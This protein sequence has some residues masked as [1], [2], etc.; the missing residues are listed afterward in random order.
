MDDTTLPNGMTTRQ[1]DAWLAEKL[2]H[3]QW[4]KNGDCRFLAPSEGPDADEWVEY[5]PLADGTER[6]GVSEIPLLSTTWEGMGMVEE[7]MR[8][9][10]WTLS[11]ITKLNGEAEAEFWLHGDTWVLDSFKA[12]AYR[13][14]MAVALAAKAALEGEAKDGG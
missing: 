1:L 14:P 6:L 11:L 5:F 7:A 3:Y 2:L 4:R 12:Q 13:A 10:R 9:R 8:M